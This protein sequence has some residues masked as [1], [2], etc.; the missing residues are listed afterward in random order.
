ML[1]QSIESTDFS[2]ENKAFNNL[3]FFHQQMEFSIDDNHRVFEMAAGVENN[4]EMMEYL[5]AHNCPISHLDTSKS[6]AETGALKQFDMAF[7][8]WIF[9][10][11]L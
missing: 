5:M 1:S 8:R 10:E 11:E 4:I 2:C 6:A 7:G 9:V 3:K